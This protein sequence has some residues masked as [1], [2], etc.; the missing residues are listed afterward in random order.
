MDHVI[1]K[2]C[3]RELSIGLSYQLSDIALFT[4][5]VVKDVQFPISYRGGVEVSVVENLVG[6]AGI[7]VEPLTFSGGLGY[8]AKF[9]AVNIAVQRHEYRALGYSPAID[10]KISW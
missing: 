5:D 9:W 8:L 3:P 1:M 2:S 6:R 7:T 10:F 4:S